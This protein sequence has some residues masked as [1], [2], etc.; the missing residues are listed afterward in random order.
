MQGV[1]GRPLILF[2]FF[3]FFLFFRGRRASGGEGACLAPRAGKAH[4]SET[5]LGQDFDFFEFR[6]EGDPGGGEN[7]SKIQ[8][9]RR[10]SPS[11]VVVGNMCPTLA[12]KISCQYLEVEGSYLPSKFGWTSSPF[13]PPKLQLCPWSFFPWKTN[14]PGVTP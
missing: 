7:P 13:L 8:S 1:S 6:G 12:Q 5:L 11:E 14:T 4:G 3:F 2:F 9:G 10:A